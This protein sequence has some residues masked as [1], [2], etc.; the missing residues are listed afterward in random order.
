MNNR[1][2][3]KYEML[4]AVYGFY[5]DKKGEANFNRA[6]ASLFEGVNLIVKEIALNEKTLQEGNKGKIAS[7]DV[8][9]DELST[10]ALVV[11]GALYGYAAGISD[12]EL[13]KVSDINS[14]SLKKMRNSE[15]PIFVES[16]FD[17]ADSI[18]DGLIA[19]GIS[20]E[21]R[22]SAR[23]LL[24]DYLSK[25]GEVNS[26]RTSRTKSH[27]NVRLLLTK[28]DEKLKVLDKLM[29]GVKVSNPDLYTEY[30]SARV[31]ID[32]AVSHNTGSSTENKDAG[33]TN[34]GSSTTTT[35][36]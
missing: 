30:E 3:N 29:L 2:L 20:A 33:S 13:L 19:Y 14:S 17:K 16:L 26:G 1:E 22:T 21:Y 24:N 11:A 25:Y 6:T 12:M 32:K 23:T 34:T 28:A 15:L 35:V 7:R 10:T 5:L 18:G 4:V 31:V 9:Q 8:T 36:N 27:E